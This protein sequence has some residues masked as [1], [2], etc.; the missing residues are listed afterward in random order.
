MSK[1]K[2]QIAVI[3]QGFVG[4]PMSILIADK[5][6]CLVHGIDKNDFRG[7]KLKEILDNN[8]L[9]FKSNDVELIRKFKK[10]KKKR[11]YQIS[12]NLEPIKNCNTIIVSISFDFKSKNSLENLKKLFFNIIKKIKKKTLIILETT[13]PPGTCDKIIVPEIEKNLKKR[14]MRLNDI[15]FAY[16]YERVTPGE[17]YYNSI[18][19]YY[20][21]YAGVNNISSQKCKIFLNK[22]INTKKFPLTKLNSLKDC[23]TCKIIE[24]TYRAVNIAL[25]DEFTNFSIEN[26]IDIKNI[27][28]AIRIRKTH[29]NIMNPG[30][31]VGGYCLTKDPK[32]LE[33]SAKNILN[34]NNKFPITKKSILINSKMVTTSLKYIKKK[35]ISFKNKK[36]LLIGISYKED[37]DDIR[38][39]PSVDLAQ[40]LKNVGAKVEIND[41]LLTNNNL[42]PFNFVKEPDFSKY[43]C[44]LFCV[45]H[46]KV[47]KININYL[48][49]KPMYFDLNNIFKN[50]NYKI[51]KK[52]K[53]KFFEIS[54]PL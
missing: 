31:G 43:D 47:K 35:I 36:I 34:T 18:S 1:S 40:K 19:N 23:E 30:L 3:G 52:K 54:R 8:L 38:F 22:I 41:P 42:L 21:V 51:L 49:K 53:I 15:Y 44:V 29:S 28:N 39:S 20:R 48:N 50:I 2:N 32:F 33:Y 4:I 37:V 10:V 5:I 45:G 24:N 25:I 7:K 26:S 14:K 17:N 46:K 6:N 12:L 16:S 9:P 11:N 27:L 13:L